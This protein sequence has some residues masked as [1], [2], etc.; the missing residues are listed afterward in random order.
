MKRE[1]LCTACEVVSMNVH[2]P[3][4]QINDED[5]RTLLHPYPGEH[6]LSVKGNSIALFLCDHCAK[7]ILPGDVCHAVS[8]WSDRLTKVYGYYEWEDQ[9]IVLPTKGGDSQ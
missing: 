9:F 2:A 6:R 1:I 7:E 3:E 8:I 4:Q 5:D